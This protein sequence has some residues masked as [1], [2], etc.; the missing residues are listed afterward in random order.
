[1]TVNELCQ[2]FNVDIFVKCQFRYSE[3]ARFLHGDESIISEH[4]EAHVKVS[5]PM[6]IDEIPRAW[7]TMLRNS[8]KEEEDNV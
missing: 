6:K 8:I 3:I 4:A 7:R 1:M 5:V 2:Q